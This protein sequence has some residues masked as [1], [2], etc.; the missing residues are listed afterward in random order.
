MTNIRKVGFI[1]T[2]TMGKPMARNLVKA[3]FDVGVRDVREEPITELEAAGATP[4]GSASEVAARSEVVISMVLN[5]A[6][7]EDV[8]FGNQGVMSGARPGTKLVIGSTIGPGPMRKIAQALMGSNVTL[9]D[10]AVANGYPAAEKGT[11]TIMVGGDSDVI[12]EVMPVLRAVGSTILRAGSIGAAQT[13]KLANNLTQAINII[14][15][16]EGLSL[17]VKGG[18][19]LGILKDIL[20][21]SS[22]NSYVLQAWD[23]LG[24]RW[25]K[26]LEHRTPEEQVPN[27]CKDLRLAVEFARELRVPLPVGSLASAIWEGGLATGHDDPRI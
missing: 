12:E 6:Q 15:L 25:K 11:L 2:G 14:A 26:R 1:G 3:G 13:A 23:K 5:L 27:L 24:P 21:K 20:K 18:V 16:L 17:G 22:A 10:A 4:Y 7:T 8:V 9:I 19:E